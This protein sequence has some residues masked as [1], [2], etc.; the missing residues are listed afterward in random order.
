MGESS[1]RAFLVG[2]GASLATAIAGCSDED[3]PEP[4]L[5]AVD[6]L[7]LYRDGDGWYDYPGQVGVQVTVENTDADRHR[8]TLVVALS[9]EGTDET[10]RVERDVELPGGT[11][12]GVRVVFDVAGDGDASY[13]AEAWFGE[14]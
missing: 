5:H 8:G 1:R 2:A 4:G 9:R 3:D 10:R 11:T 12:R 13:T 7:T 6:V 14:R